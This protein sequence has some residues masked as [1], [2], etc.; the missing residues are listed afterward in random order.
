MENEKTLLYKS[1]SLQ[2]S[3]PQGILFQTMNYKLR[4]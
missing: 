3:S 2:K 1:D 4:F